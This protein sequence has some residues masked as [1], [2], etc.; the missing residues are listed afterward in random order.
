MKLFGSYTSPFVRHCRIVLLETETQC[1][2]IETDTN[3]SGLQ[4]PTKRVP[5]LQAEDIFLTDSNSIVKYLREKSGR[6]FCTSAKE[7]D[8]FCLVNT[9]METTVNLFFLKRDGVDIQA[10]PYLQRQSDRIQS[11]LSELNQALLPGNLPYND[12]K[13]RLACFI[14]WAKLRQQLEFSHF[15]NLE[16]IYHE[17]LDYANFIATQPPQA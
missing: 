15:N 8:H 12:I 2:F 9:L 14:G 17:A 5:Y 11:T 16:G 1:D 4:S 6:S 7:L 10:I 13:I 3:A